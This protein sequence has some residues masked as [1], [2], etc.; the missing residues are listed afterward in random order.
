MM[1]YHFIETQFLVNQLRRNSFQTSP[2]EVSSD[3]ERSLV[4]SG[5]LLNRGMRRF[6]FPMK[7]ISKNR[8]D[9]K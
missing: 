5:K 7:I 6:N 4:T 9:F 3:V 2:P 1:L 8:G